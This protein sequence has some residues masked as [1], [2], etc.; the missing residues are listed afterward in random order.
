M[1]WN[2]I[3][4]IVTGGAGAIG[5]NI[6][7][8]L[9]EKKVKKIIIIDDCSSGTIRNIPKSKKITII[10]ND[11]VEYEIFKKILHE[12]VSIIFHLAAHFAN[13]NSVEHP[14]KDLKTNAIGTINVLKFAKETQKSQMQDCHVIYA[15]S[16]CVYGNKKIKLS[17]N[18]T[19]IDLGTP[20]AISKLTGEYYC[21]FYAKQ[22]DIPVTILR[23]FNSFGP[24]EIHGKY[25]NVI[26]NFIAKSLLGKSLIITGTGKETRDF[27]FVKDTSKGTIL[28]AELFLKN[29]DNFQTGEII[30]IGSGIQRKIE[31]VASAINK[32]TNNHSKTKYKER[33]YWDHVIH[34][35]SDI[36]KA[37]KKISYQPST[38]FEKGLEETINWFRRTQ[39]LSVVI[40]MYNEEKNA[41]NTIYKVHETLVKNNIIHQIVAINDC[42][43]DSTKEILE[44]IN[45]K[46]QWCK[47]IH[48]RENKGPGGA[49]RTGFT[50]AEG[51]FILTMDADLSFDPKQIPKLWEQRNDFDVIIGSQH[52]SSSKMINIPIQRVIVSKVAFILDKIMKRSNLLS[53]S[54]FFDLYI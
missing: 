37:K 40:P 2:N 25:R 35:V 54:N 39:S 50:E 23:Y 38:N 29:R 14:I 8:D 5:S 32:I 13:Q 12:K 53:Y 33:R 9:L 21:Q 7:R 36:S 19:D 44:D 31:Y 42:S 27:T 26:P 22:Y 28:A 16:S 43:N 4:V 49:F 1:D 3:T 30:N 15:S 45:K 47:V 46:E 20:Y 34:R 24:Y 51:A 6:V 52:M 17:E 10:Q 48:H 18:T 41:R 11:I